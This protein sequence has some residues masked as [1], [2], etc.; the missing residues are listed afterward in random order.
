M[1]TLY[2]PGM[3]DHKPPVD[4]P[5]CSWT[6]TCPMADQPWPPSSC[7]NDPP[8]TRDPMDASPTR[9][10]PTHATPPPPGP[11]GARPPVQPGPGGGPPDRRAPFP[12]HAPAGPLELEFAWQQD[13]LD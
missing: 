1:S 7:G 5:S 13:V 11:R 9:G 3:Y 8:C 6:S 10:P 2:G 4:C 12:G